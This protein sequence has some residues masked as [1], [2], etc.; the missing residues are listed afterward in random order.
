[1]PHKEDT[2]LGF[3]LAVSGYVL[4]GVFPIYFYLVRDVNA[5]E[6]L[7]HRIIWSMVLLLLIGLFLSKRLSWLDLIKTRESLIACLVSALFLSANWLIYIWAVANQMV[8]EG[9]LGYFI[10]PLVSVLMAVAFLGERLN[11]FQLIAILF[12][13][14]GVLFLIIK[15]GYIPWVALSL[16]LTFATYGLIHKRFSIDAFAGLTLE[17]LLTAPLAIIY[18]AYVFMNGHN[19]FLSGQLMTDSLLLAAGIITTLPLFLFLASLSNLRLSTVGLLQFIVP[20]LQFFVAIYILNEAMNADKLI[21]FCF[22]WLGLIIFAYDVV[23]K[24]KHKNVSK[25]KDTPN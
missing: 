6:V 8:L 21:A 2:A 23:K 14:A 18:M 20:T 16:A 3:W 7:S 25:S 5:L 4:W 15:A 11:K 13:L 24:R 9:S 1:M 22:I 10:N 17:T 12:A 19:A